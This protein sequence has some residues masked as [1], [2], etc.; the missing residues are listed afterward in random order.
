V[1]GTLQP[2][3]SAVDA[4]P[5]ERA[6]APA[7][8]VGATGWTVRCTPRRRVV[9]IELARG[10]DGAGG[11]LYGKLRRHGLRAT[12][13]EWDVLHR[14]R[15][16]GLRV[17]D[18]VGV[19]DDGEHAL[20]LMR[21]APGRPVQALLR[22]AAERGQ[23]QTVRAFLRDVAA[24][25]VARLHAAGWV[26]RDLYWNHW[27]APSLGE[28]PVWIDV[29]RAFRPR[30]RWHRWRLKD[31]SGLVSSARPPLSRTDA[32]RALLAYAAHGGDDPRPWVPAIVER[33]RRVRERQPRFG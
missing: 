32:L 23:W 13:G 25:E 18:P 6:V 16:V 12:L 22:E 33:A 4:G 1:T 8:L 31:L 30:H 29:E 14:L 10:T 19:W 2:V 15:D 28:R 24:A 17:P 11:T 5:E 7:V 26:F 9:R 27:F 3:A 20:L 21:A